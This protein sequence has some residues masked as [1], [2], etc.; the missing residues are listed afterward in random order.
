MVRLS[1]DRWN[2]LQMEH[3]ACSCSAE[4]RSYLEGVY[5]LHGSEKQTGLTEVTRSLLLKLASVR[6]VVCCQCLVL[7]VVSVWFCLLSVSGVVCCQCQVLFAVNVWCCLLSVSGDVYC[8]C[9]V[10]FAVSVR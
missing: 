7:F 8:Q 6:N 4:D 1:V 2:T 10:L 3:T 9:Q 5:I